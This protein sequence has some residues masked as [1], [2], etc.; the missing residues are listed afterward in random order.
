MRITYMTLW[1]RI[2]NHQQSE[3]FSLKIEIFCTE[4]EGKELQQFI[5]GAVNT[6]VPK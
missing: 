4:K 3:N 2:F 5:A 1:K 6:D